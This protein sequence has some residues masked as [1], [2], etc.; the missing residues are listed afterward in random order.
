M[1]SQVI[2]EPS[3]SSL[4]PKLVSVSSIHL[5][6]LITELKIHHL[7]SLIILSFVTPVQSDYDQSKS[8]G[9]TS[10]NEKTLDFFNYES[11][12]SRISNLSF[13]TCFNGSVNASPEKLIK[14]G[15]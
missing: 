12:K 4:C 5:S 10:A 13:H 14:T 6:Q 9:N 2:C 7:Y 8:R 11:K 15:V 1:E 3:M